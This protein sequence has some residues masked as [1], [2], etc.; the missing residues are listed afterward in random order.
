MAWAVV[1]RWQRVLGARGVHPLAVFR[2]TP[3]KARL[4]LF[5]T[6]EK[7]VELCQDERQAEVFLQTKHS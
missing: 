5:K 3:K 4:A 1:P 6:T 2:N 7:Y